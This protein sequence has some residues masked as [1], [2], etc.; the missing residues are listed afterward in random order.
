MENYKQMSIKSAERVRR[1]G[2]D[3]G[4][5]CEVTSEEQPLP[6]MDDFYKKRLKQDQSSKLYQLL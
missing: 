2:T 5:F 6:A 1:A 4:I 3:P